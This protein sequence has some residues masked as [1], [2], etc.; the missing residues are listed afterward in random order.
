[1]AELDYL[2]DAGFEYGNISPLEYATGYNHVFGIYQRLFQEARENHRN[3]DINAAIKREFDALTS[4]QQDYIKLRSTP[5][6]LF[7]HAYLHEKVAQLLCDST[8]PPLN[9]P[10]VAKALTVDGLLTEIKPR[11]QQWNNQ[12][13]DIERLKNKLANQ[14]NNNQFVAQCRAWSENDLTVQDILRNRVDQLITF[15]G[16]NVRER[17]KKEQTNLKKVRRALGKSAEM[18]KRIAGREPTHIFLSGKILTVKSETTGLTYQFTKSGDLLEKTAY[19]MRTV[20]YQMR[21]L[22]DG[23]SLARLCVYIENT[24][25][26]DQLGAILLYIRSGED[27]IFLDKAN[28]FEVGD[29]DLF[30]A[31]MEAAGL[32]HKKRFRGATLE[33][34]QDVHILA[35]TDFIDGIEITEIQYGEL[36][37]YQRQVC[38]LEAHAKKV[39]QSLINKPTQTLLDNNHYET[40]NKGKNIKIN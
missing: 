34:I 3:M 1:M 33:T 25:V 30:N 14:E 29:D 19:A 5:H 7:G 4:E 17:M 24:P 13:R 27:K 26:L 28:F 6:L 23:K 40:S 10:E 15:A 38:D 35:R 16:M 9:D 32:G 21:M 12:L 36:E 22:K 18:L 31:A 37:A 11:I 2:L 39:I 20:P 8:E